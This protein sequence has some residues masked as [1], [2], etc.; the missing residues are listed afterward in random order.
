MVPPSQN[1]AAPVL[2]YGGQSPRIPVGALLLHGP[3]GPAGPQTI[4]VR[5]TANHLWPLDEAPIVP[6]GSGPHSRSTWTQEEQTRGLPLDLSPLE[7]LLK[8]STRTKQMAEKYDGTIDWADYLKQFEMVDTWNGWSEE[9][10]AAQFS[11]SLN[12]RWAWADSFSDAHTIMSYGTQV[13][14]LSQRFKP[15]EHEE[16]YKAEFRR[17]SRGKDETFLE[18][19]HGIRRLA[20]WAFPKINF[21]AWEEMVVDQFLL[22]LSEAE[23]R[24]HVSLAYPGNVDQ[25]ITLATEYETVSQSMKGIVPT[26]PRQVAA[27]QET[28]TSSKGSSN[29]ED[30]LKGLIDL[31]KKQ[32]RSGPG[33]RR[34]GQNQSSTIVCFKCNQAGHIARYCPHQ[35]TEQW[36]PA[37]V[38]QNEK[39]GSSN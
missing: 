15:I 31:V 28:G 37:G 34:E 30:L 36:T 7:P 32:N 10:K 35:P 9:E 3:P 11:M 26:K 17:R 29:T 2:A 39:E 18:F 12:A 33:T 23:M 38:T 22:G 14:A 8:L 1:S 5:G 21:E 16:A 4:P 27:V 6:Q 13:K 25:A 20:I 24:R 19:G